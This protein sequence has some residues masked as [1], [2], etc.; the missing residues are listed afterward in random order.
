L[1]SASYSCI[2]KA[3]LSPLAWTWHRQYDAILHAQMS[4]QDRDEAF[5]VLACI[6]TLMSCLASLSIDALSTS[7]TVRSTSQTGQRMLVAQ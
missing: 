5:V 1:G 4:A 3:A 7:S 6:Q 2:V